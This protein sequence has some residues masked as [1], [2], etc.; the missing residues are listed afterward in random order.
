MSQDFSTLAE[1][2]TF[3]CRTSN[4]EC[5]IG[6]A[7]KLFFEDKGWKD[8]REARCINSFF[9]DEEIRGTRMRRNAP[10]QMA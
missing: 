4:F 3:F 7:V 10:T 5:K 2:A 6:D 1:V 9:G 8:L